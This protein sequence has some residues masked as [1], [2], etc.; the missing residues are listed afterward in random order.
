M[1]TRLFVGCGLLFF[2]KIISAHI[3][4]GSK[5]SAFKFA[6]ATKL[7]VQQE[8]LI[9]GGTI[10]QSSGALFDGGMIQ[11]DDSIL[12]ID[13]VDN[14]FT[15]K[16]DPTSTYSIILDGD[17]TFNAQPGMIT[18]KIAISGTG[19]R[20]EG[21][22]NF[23]Q[24][25]AVYF[26]NGGAEL[27]F[28]LKGGINKNIVLNGGTINLVAGLSLGDDVIIS[29]GGIFNG[30]GKNLSL[31]GNPLIW[32]AGTM[33][34]KNSTVLSL[35]GNV[36]LQ[37]RWNFYDTCYIIGNGN[38]LDIADGKLCLMDS[39]T[40]IL[41]NVSIKGIFGAGESDP[42]ICPNIE[43]GT[44]SR[45]R[46]NHAELK[47]DSSW[48]VTS[49]AIY[50]ENTATVITPTKTKLIFAPG[51]GSL[52]V[53]GS[54][55]WY[56][57]L[58]PYNYQNIPPSYLGTND[59]FL[60]N[61]GI[62]KA[63]M[64]EANGGIIID[65]NT[66]T[67]GRSVN[68]F[69]TNQ[70]LLTRAYWWDTQ[71]SLPTYETPNNFDVSSINPIKILI[72]SVFGGES[73]VDVESSVVDFIPPSDISIP[74]ISVYEN[75]S[76]VLKRMVFN[77][78]K[79][80]YLSLGD[81]ANI[82]FG[83]NLSINLVTGAYEINTTY[84]FQ[85]TCFFDAKNSTITFGASGGIEIAPNSYLDIANVT[86]KNLNGTKI[87]CIDSTSLLAF[88]GNVNL[89]LDDHF[90][91]ST[92]ALF[93]AQNSLLDIHGTYSFIYGTSG[94]FNIG[95]ASTVQI[96]DGAT[97]YYAPST[98]NRDLLIFHDEDSTLKLNNGTLASTTTGMRL[99]AGTLQ[100]KGERNYIENPGAIA[101]S[102]GITIGYG[103]FIPS[104]Y[105]NPDIPGYEQIMIG[106]PSLNMAVEFI[107][108][109]LTIN[110]GLLVWANVEDLD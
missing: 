4:F 64:G 107:E 83:P 5:Q 67:P 56:E 29:G 38:I 9:D 79:F 91:F 52:L 97:F 13:A 104:W 85:G 14:L 58:S 55:L 17:K 106:D 69:F 72:S 19:N 32:P 51:D 88:R 42:S 60:I 39:A 10:Q 47:M 99:A 109:K 40:L 87:R 37:G 16:Y 41:S 93:T 90:S 63:T 20:L 84:T 43:I 44:G 66:T 1:K 101:L 92:G 18:P 75:V 105:Y 30:Y 7:I 6:D 77:N 11:F 81:G 98:A 49:G 34:W 15:G 82:L 65:S 102:E 76:A 50:V 46:L 71:T 3:N 54:V 89:Y 27:T 100:I 68:E 78:F 95:A 12:A 59:T 22:V 80:D 36:T 70:Q 25:D 108:G 48:T 2:I 26:N 23:N 103:N 53:D 110:S 24:D 96:S 35:K 31:G 86:F 74:L 45:L 8:M 61:K 94:L 21:N 73:S 57:S 28:A 33:H 62:I